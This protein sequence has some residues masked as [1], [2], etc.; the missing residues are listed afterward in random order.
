[1]AMAM[2]AMTP[3]F[4]EQQIAEAIE[5]V[6]FMYLIWIGAMSGLE[7]FSHKETLVMFRRLLRQAECDR[8]QLARDLAMK[9]PDFL[10]RQ[11]LELWAHRRSLA[12]D[13][14]WACWIAFGAN[15]GIRVAAE[16]KQRFGVEID[17]TNWRQAA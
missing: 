6:A 17:M 13:R 8:I 5:I 11:S 1:M 9:N 16:I 10:R 14:G 15:K 4:S 2:F 3:E 12:V 7:E